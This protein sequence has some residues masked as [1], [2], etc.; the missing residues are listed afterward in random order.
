MYMEC[1]KLAPLVLKLL[2]DAKIVSDIRQASDWFYSASTALLTL[3]FP[4]AFI[5]LLRAASQL[6]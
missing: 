4:L 6:L 1:L 2:E 5:W 3:T